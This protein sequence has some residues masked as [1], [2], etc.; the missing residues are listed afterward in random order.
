MTACAGAL[1][2]G[3]GPPCRPLTATQWCKCKAVL[4][5]GRGRVNPS[6]E[7]QAARS[8]HGLRP[9]ITDT[10]KHSLCRG[11]VSMQSGRSCKGPRCK[12]AL[13]SQLLQRLGLG[14]SSD[15]DARGP[16]A[17]RLAEIWNQRHSLCRGWVLAEGKN[18][19]SCSAQERMRWCAIAT[20]GG[21][22]KPSAA[23]LS[24]SRAA[25]HRQIKDV[26]LC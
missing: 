6:S 2:L 15:P 21:T 7:G 22:Q 26:T 4:H 3:G 5:P 20:G 10:C 25:Q 9:G 14:S 12:W 17:R 18:G 8:E 11:C 23:M 16:N 1:G 24:C 19:P 13:V